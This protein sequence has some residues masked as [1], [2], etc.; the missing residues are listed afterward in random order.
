MVGRPPRFPP[1]ELDVRVTA[2]AT[3]EFCERGYDAATVD[4]IV[5]ASGV[6]KP[7]LYRAFGSKSQLYCMLL[8]RIANE[9]ASAAMRSFMNNPG[10]PTQ[11]FRAIISSWFDALAQHPDQWRMLNTASS[12]DPHVLTTLQRVASMQLENDVTMIRTFLPNLPEDEVQPIAEAIRG[13]L[14]A[15]GTW[16]LDHPSVERSVPI[17]AMTRLCRGLFAVTQNPNQSA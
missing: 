16:W 13:S 5:E 3:R 7:V 15:I 9:L 8:E 11:R 10:E 12:T 1:K 14:R 17:D 6:S 4:A 2:A